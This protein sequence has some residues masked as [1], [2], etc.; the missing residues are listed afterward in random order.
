VWLQHWGLDRNPFGS[1]NSP[2]VSLPS[3]DEAVARLVYSIERAE[4]FVAF[5]A[6]AGLGKTTV[7]RR[8]IDETRSVRRRWVLVNALSE[9]TQLLGSVAVGLGLPFRE[10][11]SPERVWRSVARAVRSASM[12]G[13]HLVFVIDGGDEQ[14]TPA[15]MKD[16]A[17]LSAVGSRSAPTVSL[18]RV[19]RGTPHE[20][21]ESSDRWALTIGLERLTC[22]QAGTYL[23]AKLAD[24]GCPER[25]F[26]P[27]ALTRLHSWSEGVPRGLDQLATLSLMAGALLG[28]EVVTPEVVDGVADGSLVAA[29]PSPAT[30]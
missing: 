25:V 6:D 14:L 17:A 23:S 12:E 2:Y 28:L 29:N 18:I 7:V 24:A 1:A 20:S 5:F 22:S 16:L 30:R 26:T 3:H 15:T 21:P 13:C 9:R 4:R 8:A 10:G 19:A 27:R 11:S